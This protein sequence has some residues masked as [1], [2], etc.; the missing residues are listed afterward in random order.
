MCLSNEN[1]V[2]EV[3]EMGVVIQDTFTPV[4]ISSP[5][6]PCLLKMSW[7]KRCHSLDS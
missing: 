3:V 2:S 7:P 4:L 5:I 6:P 1:Q